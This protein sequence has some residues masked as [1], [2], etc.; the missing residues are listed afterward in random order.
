[1]TSSCERDDNGGSVTKV[2]DREQEE[3]VAE[4]VQELN[5]QLGYTPEEFIPGLMVAARELAA[6]GGPA[7]RDQVLDEAVIILEDE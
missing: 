3:Q 4:Q 5:D 7:W 6:R 1:M 2:L